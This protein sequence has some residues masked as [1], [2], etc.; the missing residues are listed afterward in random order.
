MLSGVAGAFSTG[1]S[2]R[3]LR[4]KTDAASRIVGIG[5]AS[6]GARSL[7][8]FIRSPRGDRLHGQ[9][10][11]FCVATGLQPSPRRF[12]T[13]SGT[14]TAMGRRAMLRKIVFGGLML[15]VLVSVIFS[16]VGVLAVWD[17]AELFGY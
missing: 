7:G 4:R 9:G 16:F 12:S 17:P 14:M 10:T 5:G 15:L 3:S 1:G 2:G 6:G 8:P 13:G 11:G